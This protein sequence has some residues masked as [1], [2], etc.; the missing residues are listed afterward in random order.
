MLI[1]FK[2]S[3]TSIFLSIH[4]FTLATFGCYIR[5]ICIVWN[6]TLAAFQFCSKHPWKT[7]HFF[8]LIFILRPT[9]LAQSKLHLVPLKMSVRWMTK[10]KIRREKYANFSINSFGL[11]SFQFSWFTCFTIYFFLSISNWIEFNYR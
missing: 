1:Y 2:A 8:L 5:F 7:C 9:C 6:S 4:F 3:E 11:I 10:K